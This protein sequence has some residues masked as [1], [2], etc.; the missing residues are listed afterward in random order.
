VQSTRLTAAGGDAPLNLPSRFVHRLLPLGVCLIVI[1]AAC[2]MDDD[3]PDGDPEERPEEGPGEPGGEQVDWKPCEQFGQADCAEFTV[4]VDYSA[5]DG[6]TLTLSLAR[7]P[8]PADSRIG[9]LFTN[10]GGPGATAWDFAIG[11]A[12]ALPTEITDRFDIVGV[13]PRG[14]EGDT[15]DCGV[16]IREVYAVDHTPASPEDEELLL[17]ASQ[18]Y[19]DACDDHARDLLP[20]MGTRDI[21]RDLDALREALGEDQLNYLGYSY[22]TVIGQVYADMFPDR[23]RSMVLDGIVQLGPA[24][25]DMARAQAQGFERA[26]AAFADDCD[27]SDRCPLA[28]DAMGAIEELIARVDATPIAASDDRDLGPG[29]LKLALALPLYNP[30]DWPTLA[31]SVARALDSDGVPMLNLADRYLDLADF[32]VYYAV[33]CLDFAWPD[34]PETLLAEGADAAGESPHFGEAVVNDYLRCT[35]WPA[36]AEPLPE[37][38]APDTPTILLVSSTGDPATPHEGAVEVAATLEPAILLTYEGQGHG[39]VGFGVACVDDA[40]IDYLVNLDP[41]ADGTICPA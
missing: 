6:E 13:D 8:A 24:G 23:V 18:D 31:T 21:A 9:T 30:A 2:G 40:V 1:A 20:H 29:E 27:A 17:E 36:E 32:D 37:I 5:P 16:D 4:P 28:P 12:L 39:V 34:D 22:G 7:V 25:P 14:L 26:L 11:L 19:V 15:L 3:D 33:S 41:P 38:T 35:M 10:P